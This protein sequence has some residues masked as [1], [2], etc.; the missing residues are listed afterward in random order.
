MD[1]GGTI[2]PIT[3]VDPQSSKK[4][5]RQVSKMISFPLYIP[6][7]EQGEASYQHEAVETRDES[8]KGGETH[9]PPGVA[10]AEGT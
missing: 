7:L 8:L 2:Q 9:T 1:L 3:T 5:R 6:S 4:E 10:C